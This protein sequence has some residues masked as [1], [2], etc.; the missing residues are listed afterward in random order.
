MNDEKPPIPPAEQSKPAPSLGRVPSLEHEQVYG[1][2]PRLRELD[3]EIEQE[4]QEAL[5]GMSDKEIYG[6]P[7]S[8]GKQQQPSGK[9]RLKG[10]ILRVHGQDVFVDLPGSRSQGILPITQFP[11]GAPAIGTEIDVH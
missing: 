6:D 9:G 11:E 4:L 3:A 5:G 8:Q 1:S 10:K 7:A 2:G